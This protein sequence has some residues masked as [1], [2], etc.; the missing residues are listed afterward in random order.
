MW[1]ATFQTTTSYVTVC[2][3]LPDYH[4]Q[5]S[6]RTPQMGVRIWT[7]KSVFVRQNGLSEN[8]VFAFAQGLPASTAARRRHHLSAF[9]RQMLMMYR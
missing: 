2:F 4:I 6:L 9:V 7:Q 8:T 3:D 1:F 5:Q